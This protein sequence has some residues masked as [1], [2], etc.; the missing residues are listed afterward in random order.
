MSTYLE[1]EAEIIF[2]G[3]DRDAFIQ[4]YTESL[5]ALANSQTIEYNHLPI[6]FYLTHKLE[7]YG[8]LTEEIKVQFY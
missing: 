7:F 8:R 1:R 3:G 5:T 6:I 2:K 4:L